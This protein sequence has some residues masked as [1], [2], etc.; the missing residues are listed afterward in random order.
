MILDEIG[1]DRREAFLR[2]LVREAADI[3]MAGFA[4]Q[5]SE[6]VSMKGPQDYLT[7]TDGRVEAF[8]RSRIA[9][10]FPDD[11]FLGEESGG[12][13]GQQAWVVDPIDGTANFARSIPHF[14]ISIAFVANGETQLGVVMNPVLNE[15]Y[16]ARL[17]RGATL[18]ERAIRVSATAH[19]AA[20]SVELGWSNRRPLEQYIGAV[21]ALF[22]AGSNVRR[23]SCGALGLAY[24][25]D[26][27][28]DGY[29]E[30]HMNSW[31]CLAGLLLVR[32]AGG[33]TG[34]FLSV[35]G[36]VEGAPVLAAAP[37]AA[38]FLSEAT[39]IP[40]L[41]GND[42]LAELDERRTA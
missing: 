31:D 27:R 2:D 19:V 6:V 20:T 30:L 24:V 5:G 3:A 42:V 29:G 8:V 39:G 25:A 9:A 14:C 12:L 34:P 4:R 11:G 16:F 1:I 32:E 33:M 10:D 41:V 21:R 22:E 23:A 36:L 28:S 7:E 37:G 38:R 35:G 13:P 18:N 26:G 40:I 15:M 17:G